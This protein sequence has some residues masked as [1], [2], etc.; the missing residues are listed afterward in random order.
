MAKLHNTFGTGHP[1]EFVGA[2]IGQPHIGGQRIRHQGLSYTR[3][4]RLTAMRQIAQPRRLVDRRADVVALVAQL[5]LAGV[6]PDPQADRRERRPLQLQRTR[7]R[8]GGPR[9]RHHETVA[10]PLLHRAHTAIGGQQRRQRLIQT[11]KGRRHLL[12]LGLP[13]PGRVLDVCQQQRHGARRQ[14]PAYAQLAPVHQRQVRAW[15]N[16][17][18]ASQPAAGTTHKTSAQTRKTG[19]PDA[20]ATA[21]R[22]PPS[23]A[24]CRRSRRTAAPRRHRHAGRR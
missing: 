9:E 20:E 17:A 24:A 7:H 5:H 23:A 3:Q 15:I 14:Q 8:V 13:Q 1:T 4:H 2:Q 10:L 21:C 11:R 12:G 16:L 19:R 22:T 18:H 6:H